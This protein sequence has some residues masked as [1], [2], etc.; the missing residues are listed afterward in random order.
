MRF[1]QRFTSFQPQKL[2]FSL[3]AFTCALHLQNDAAEKILCLLPAINLVLCPSDLSFFYCFTFHKRKILSGFSSNHDFVQPPNKRNLLLLF[4]KDLCDCHQKEGHF[5]V[6]RY[7]CSVAPQSF[8]SCTESCHCR[9]NAR[10]IFTCHHH[11]YSCQLCS[12]DYACHSTHRV[13]RV[14]FPSQSCAL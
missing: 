1:A 4:S 10:T 14:S 5:S 13:D 12:H 2:T 7:R 6:Q 8:Q 11:N 9:P 3:N